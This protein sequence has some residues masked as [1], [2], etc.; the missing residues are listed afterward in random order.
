M[1]T[2]TAEAFPDS[3]RNEEEK[4]KNDWS[5]VTY[6]AVASVIMLA[7]GELWGGQCPLCGGD[8]Y[9]DD[10]VFLHDGGGETQYSGLCPLLPI[11]PQLHD[12]GT[13]GFAQ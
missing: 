5:F 4:K 7:A 8:G 13:V 9:I 6:L 12:G 2:V 1:S 11:V 3:G 10:V